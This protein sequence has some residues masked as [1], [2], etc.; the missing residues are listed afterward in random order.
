MGAS[1]KLHAPARMADRALRPPIFASSEAFSKRFR[2]EILKNYMKDSFTEVSHRL[3]RLEGRF[4]PKI[5]RLS[6]AP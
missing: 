2:K 5:G 3:S 1:L 6:E 4:R